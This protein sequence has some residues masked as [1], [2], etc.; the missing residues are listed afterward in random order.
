MDISDQ[1]R[2]GVT[3]GSYIYGAQTRIWYIHGITCD[4]QRY[5]WYDISKHWHTRDIRSI[6]ICHWNMKTY[7]R[8]QDSRCGGKSITGIWTRNRGSIMFNSAAK[9]TFQWFQVHCDLTSLSRVASL[10]PA[11]AQ[12]ATWFHKF[13]H[14]VKLL[15]WTRL[16]ARAWDRNY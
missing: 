13:F 1:C 12:A 16:S 5:R 2:P 11:W 10:N 4:N 9:S 7:Q 14:W 8:G 15:A 6:M 3:V